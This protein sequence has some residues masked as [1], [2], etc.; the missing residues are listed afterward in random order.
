MNDSSLLKM[1]N[2]PICHR[3]LILMQFLVLRGKKKSW[4]H[5]APCSLSSGFKSR[6][7]KLKYN[8]CVQPLNHV[9]LF[10]IPWTVAHQTPL[11]M[12][13]RQGYWSGLSFPSR[14]DIL[15]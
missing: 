9:Q 5:G 11:S 8:G 7:S 10:V 13:F 12:G 3:V 6:V 1:K 2:K 14:G 15:T 4:I